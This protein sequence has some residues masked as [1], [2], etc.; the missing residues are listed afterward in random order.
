MAVRTSASLQWSLMDAIYASV[1]SLRDRDRLPQVDA[2]MELAE[3]VSLA[4]Y[5]AEHAP[6]ATQAH[7]EAREPESSSESEA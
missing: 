3:D 4:V 5:N 2:L 1:S 6:H 7:R